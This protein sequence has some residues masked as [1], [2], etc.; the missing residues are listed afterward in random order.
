MAATTAQHIAARNDVD[1][2]Q[3]FIAKAEMMGVESPTS[4]I[5]N[6]MAKLI[7]VDIDTSQEGLQTITDVYAYADAIRT[8]HVAATPP[9]P[10]QNPAA[11]NDPQLEAAILAVQADQSSPTE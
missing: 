8:E 4:F 1:L 10:G 11:V 6:N 7:S 2:L 5:Q 9:P 3:R